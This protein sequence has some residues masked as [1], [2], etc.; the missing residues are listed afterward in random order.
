MKIDPKNLEWKEAHDLLT[1]IIVPR[2]IAFVSTIG[3]DGVFNVAP[4][5]LFTGI[6]HT[7]MLA[8]FSIGRKRDGH[9]KDTLVNIESSG[10]FVINI[11]TEALAEAMNQASKNYPSSVDEF[12][13]VGLNPVKADIV[14]PP[15]VAESP[16]SMECRLVQMLEFGH[17]PRYNNF[18]I[19][20]VLCV[21]IKDEFCTD[22]EIRPS[23]FRAIG[24]LGGT[25]GAAYCRTTDIFEMKR[26]D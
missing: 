5:S 13:E 22:G 19:G 4:F 7:P 20:E 15:M 12:K 3:E 18:I 24:R 6:C 23:Q 9:K 21:H 25:G 10:D 26:P 1:S 14:K 11:V 2:P 8:G 17:A 16:M